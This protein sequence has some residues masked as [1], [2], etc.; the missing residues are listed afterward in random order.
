[1]GELKENVIEWFT[2]SD[3]ITVTLTQ[4]KYINRVKNLSK[5]FVNEVK[6]AENEDGSIIATLPLKAL[7]LNLF[8]TNRAGFPGKASE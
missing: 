7:K 1:M 4:K 6:Y 8:T 5:R 3:K 2:G